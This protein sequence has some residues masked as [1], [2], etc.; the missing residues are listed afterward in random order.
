MARRQDDQPPGQADRPAQPENWS[1]AALH[2]RLDRLPA[3]H[4]SSRLNG[5]GSGKPPPPD[6]RRLELPLPGDEADAGRKPGESW[7]QAVPA[8]RAKWAEHQRRWPEEGR[9]PGDRAADEPGSWRGEGGQ[10]LNAEENTVAGHAHDR[11]ASAEQRLTAVQR[12]IQ[13]EVPGARLAGLEFR[14]KTEDRFKEKVAG[15]IKAKPDRS[16]REITDRIPDAV[17]YTYQLDQGRYVDGYW[18]VRNRLEQRGFE[19][20]LSRNSWDSPDYKGVNTRWRT[21]AGQLFEVQFHTAESFEAKQLTHEAYERLRS[22]TKPDLERPHLEAFQRE[23]SAALP[24]PDG[25]DSIA[26]YRRREV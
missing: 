17:R 21:E 25:V 23:A 24:I 15:E 8:L 16:I 4:P 26:D 18:S 13:A 7:G 1:P 11:I 10:F 14:L 19:L 12:E 6:L 22:K 9:P 3:G 20:V 5:D 2:Q